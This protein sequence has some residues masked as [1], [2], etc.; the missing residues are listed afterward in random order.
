MNTNYN[1]AV[2]FS[3]VLYKVPRYS[4]LTAEAAISEKFY[5]AEE[6][7]ANTKFWDMVVD[8]EGCKIAY[9][10][11]ARTYIL[12]DKPKR[13]APNT[14]LIRTYDA[15]N[16]EHGKVTSF[17]VCFDNFDEVKQVYKNFVSLKGIDKIVAAVLM[18]EKHAVSLAQK[19]K[20]NCILKAKKVNES[21]L[22]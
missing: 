17:R 5:A 10:N 12:A 8:S 14:L 11:T 4:I 7:L 3:G 1:N 20:S 19:R 9:K 6:K 21:V 18:L 13:H 22:A 15:D 2:S 16:K